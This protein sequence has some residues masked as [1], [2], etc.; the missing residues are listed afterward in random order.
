MTAGRI[1]CECDRPIVGEAR[2]IYRDSMSGARPN[3]WAHEVGDPQCSP[4]RPEQSAVARYLR[5]RP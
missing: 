4:G 2:E 1:C 3:D 5:R